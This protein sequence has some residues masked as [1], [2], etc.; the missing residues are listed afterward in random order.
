MPYAEKTLQYIYRLWGRPV[1][2]ETVIDED[3][4]LISYDGQKITKAAL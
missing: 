1:H 2:I 3:P 4:T